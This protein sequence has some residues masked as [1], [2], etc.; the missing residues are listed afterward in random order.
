VSASGRPGLLDANLVVYR[1]GDNSGVH[2]IYD[3]TGASLYPG[4]WNSAGVRVLY[5]SEHYSTAL[6]EKLVHLNFLVPAAMHWISISIPA[7]TSHEVFPVAAHPGWDGAS[8]A[9]CKAHGDEWVRSRRSALLFVPSIP[10]RQDRNVL[11]NLVHPEAARFRHSMPEPVPWD[12]RLFRAPGT[13]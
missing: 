11:I 7:G 13:P 1:L 5:T 10:A 6:L 4:R 3:D 8:E 9:I 2:P 12:R